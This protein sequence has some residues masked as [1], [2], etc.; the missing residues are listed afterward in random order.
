[1]SNSSTRTSQEQSKQR[2]GWESLIVI[3]AVY[4]A[5]SHPISGVALRVST[6]GAPSNERIFGSGVAIFLV[7]TRRIRWKYSNFLEGYRLP[8]DSPFTM[9]TCLSLRI[10][11]CIVEKTRAAISRALKNGHRE[12]LVVHVDSSGRQPLRA[13]GSPARGRGRSIRANRA[14]IT[15]RESVKLPVK[16]SRATSV[17]YVIPGNIASLR[18][19]ISWH[20]RGSGTGL[21]LDSPPRV[22]SIKAPLST[23]MERIFTVRKCKESPRAILRIAPGVT[24]RKPSIRSGDVFGYLQRA[25]FSR[26]NKARGATGNR[27]LFRGLHAQN[28]GPAAN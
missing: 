26:N 19:R 23:T 5:S 7:A 20:R 13:S 25:A 15:R 21:L 6:G 11:F 12:V 22:F 27:G 24:L 17:D 4:R 14:R 28:A 3:R 1:V 18:R 9:I 8:G 16:H 2:R 10:F